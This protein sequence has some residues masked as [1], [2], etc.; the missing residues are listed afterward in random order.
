MELGRAA[1]AQELECERLL[2]QAE[3]EGSSVG[4]H[5]H[6]WEEETLAGEPLER[7]SREWLCRKWV[8]RHQKAK[9]TSRANRRVGQSTEVVYAAI[10]GTAEMIAGAAATTAPVVSLRKR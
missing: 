4:D 1:Q 9:K 3:E 2:R 5:G 6:A 10:I 8:R 7:K